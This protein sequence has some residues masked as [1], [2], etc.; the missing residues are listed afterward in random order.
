MISFSGEV[1]AED[2]T[3]QLK[4]VATNNIH[5]TTINGGI[6]DLGVECDEVSTTLPIGQCPQCQTAVFTLILLI[7]MLY[8]RVDNTKWY[9][10]TF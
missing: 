9:V 7:L 1:E 5:C 6:G 4:G 10:Q 2:G 8:C 3:L